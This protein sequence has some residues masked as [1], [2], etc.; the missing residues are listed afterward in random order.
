VEEED[1]DEDGAGGADARPDGVGS[2][3][4]QVAEGEGEES[5]KLRAPLPMAMRDGPTR[6]KPWVS[7]RLTAKT[8]STQPAMST[9]IHDIR[10][11]YP[12]ARLEEDALCEEVCDL[13][14][15]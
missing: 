3:G 6:V 15:G 13:V 11:V 7:F 8:T 14:H 4:G 9:R 1:A 12:R 10:P 5:A 2:A